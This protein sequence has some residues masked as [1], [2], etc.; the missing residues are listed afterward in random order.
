MV[1]FGVHDEKEDRGS[2]CVSERFLKFM[3]FLEILGEAIPQLT[4]NIV[5]MKNNYPY[6]VENDTLF[7]IPVPVSVIS[8]VFS[9]ASVF[10]GFTTFCKYVYNYGNV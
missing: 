7:D 8:A 3:K 5:F 1:L 10:F 6:L 9:L 2:C 4:L